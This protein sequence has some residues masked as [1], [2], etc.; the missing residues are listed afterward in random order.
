MFLSHIKARH[1]YSF[2]L[3]FPHEFLMSFFKYKI[4]HIP[5][6]NILKIQNA[7]QNQDES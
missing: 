1:G 7:S 6:R 2:P 3:N 4:K 5:K